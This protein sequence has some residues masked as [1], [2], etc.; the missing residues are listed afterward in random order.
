MVFIS[1]IVY[2][3]SG[4]GG[5]PPLESFRTTE[6]LIAQ[7]CKR[8]CDILCKPSKGSTLKPSKQCTLRKKPSKTQNFD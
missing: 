4:T 8:N 6:L 3:G 5:P 7:P 2:G 1:S